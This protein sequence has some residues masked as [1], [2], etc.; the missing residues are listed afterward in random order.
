[1]LL[2]LAGK[3]A[4]VTGSSR[5]IG[6]AIARTLH[7]EGCRVALNSRHLDSLTDLSLQ[8]TG[9]IAVAGD[10]TSSSEAK[11]IVRDVIT[12]FGGLDILVCSVG[13][14]DSVMPGFE[15]YEEWQRV[16][17]LNL[18]SAT[19]V[20]EAAMEDLVESKGVILCISSICGL[21]VIPNAPLTYS[22]AKA[23]LNTY[24]KGAS[25]TFGKRGVR[26]NAIAP[27]NIL[28]QGS[29]WEKKIN[30]NPIETSSFIQKHVALNKF[31]SP[32]D[33]SNLAAFLVSDKAN[34][35]TGGIWTL[36]GGQV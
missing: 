12:C 8:L 21:A 34:F 17:S 24:I 11:R 29:A 31:G 14:G 30:N 36:D 18:W 35:A 19:N 6:F 2:N 23:A 9:S 10:V 4:L 15:Y 16:F 27:G 33:V 26:I 3:T 13:G 1:M 5:G 22:S 7:A 20:I 28:F 32:E 25:K